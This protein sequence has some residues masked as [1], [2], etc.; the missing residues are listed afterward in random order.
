MDAPEEEEEELSLMEG[1]VA[2]VKE[3]LFAFRRASSRLAEM[4]GRAYLDKWAMAA[5]ADEEEEKEKEKSK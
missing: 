5:L 2:S 1:E 4:Q 3:L